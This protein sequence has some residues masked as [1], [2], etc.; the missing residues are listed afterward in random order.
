[1]LKAASRMYN[2]P[3]YLFA[4]LDQKKEDAKIAGINLI[5]LSIG[6]PDFPTPSSIVR[7]AQEALADSA[8]HHYPGYLGTPAF[9]KA[10]AQWFENRFGVSVDA[11]NEIIA[12]IGSKEGIFHLPFAYLSNKDVAL[13]PS[14]GY[15]VYP[16]STVLAGGTPFIMPLLET[17]GFRPDI[18][19]IPDEVKRK[20]KI[21]FLNYPNNPTG[22]HGTEE[23]YEHAVN[24]AEKYNILLC[25]D[26]A[27]SE[28][29]YDGYK[30]KSILE[31]DRA[32]KYSV[33]FHSLSKTY[34][35]TGWRI[36]FAVGNRDVIHNLMKLKTNI[37]SGIFRV[38]QEAGIEALTGS[39]D[40]VAAMTQVFSKRRDLVVDGLNSLG[41][42][43]TGPLATYYIW[44]HVPKGY[45]SEEFCEILIEKAGVVVT[46]GSGFG[47]EGEGYFR[48]SITTGDEQLAAAMERLGSIS[49]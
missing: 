37:D 13:V 33:E 29:T 21:C 9:R 27:Y 20:A 10:A 6:D 5:D 48:L 45:S 47:K 28:I 31:F 34:C 1:M 2:L 42:P 30:A 11:N 40:S 8:N 14:P 38:V 17:K 41:I 15:P 26:A 12:L 46:P 4:R 24:M 3:P 19:T 36:G 23:M 7:R 25:H 39:Q 32:K 22:A 44:A 18:A 35:M 49:W 43:A 16:V